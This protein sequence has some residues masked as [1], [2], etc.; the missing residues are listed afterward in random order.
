LRR[1]VAALQVL[2][3]S[4]APPGSKE[5]AQFLHAKGRII[6][7]SESAEAVRDEIEAETTRSL[8]AGNK[9]VSPE[10][11]MLTISSPRVPNLT[12]VDM[13]GLTKIATDGQPASIVR[14]L[15]EMSRAYI[16]PKNV[17]ILAISP[18]N[19]DIATSD[20]MRL[21]REFDPAGE[22]TLGVLTKLDLMDQGTDAREVLEG[23]A[24]HLKHGWIGVVNRSQ[25]DLN[26]RLSTAQSRAKETAFFNSKPV[27][28][29]LRT[30]TEE[31]VT[32]LGQQ[33]N[34]AIVAAIPKIQVFIN[35][36][37]SPLEKELAAL[38]VAVPAER[39]A[40][41]H[42]VMSMLNEF[43]KSYEALLASGRGG[44]ERVRV[45]LEN[46]LPSTLA[47][48]PFST[49]LTLR[50]VKETIEFA[51]GVQPY[52][53]APEHGIRRIICDALELLRTPSVSIVGQAHT[54]LLECIETTVADV[55]RNNPEMQR[56]SMLTTAI[57][58]CAAMSLES[59]RDE[60]S[61]TVA[62]L[63][64]M[65]SSYLTVSYFRE[66]QAAAASQ[67]A[68]AAPDPPGA[69]APPPKPPPKSALPKPPTDSSFTPE[70]EAQLQRVSTTV[71]AYLNSV[72][73]SLKKSIPKTVVHYQARS[74]R[75]LKSF[76]TNRLSFRRCSRRRS[77][78]SRRFMRR[79]ATVRTASSV[80]CWTRTQ[81]PRK[82][83][84]FLCRAWRC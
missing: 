16:R 20:A 58:R 13:P 6:D 31:L 23:K 60:A 22:R 37:I 34:S 43:Q 41:M 46:V 63:V 76:F 52:L 48:V 53:I 49:L 59:Y 57:K 56:Y 54:V 19:A 51:D 71:S 64:D 2:Q 45:V 62:V 35:D 75:F 79:C 1:L 21:V 32:S 8:G 69:P 4:Q 72:C 78:S 65:E 68:T 74:E 82:G 66:A 33:L 39:G 70:M 61:S 10:P 44:G 26:S 7:I 50:A 17:I 55:L 9:A 30:G 38:G 5:T 77:R 73:D 3:L 12:L 67:L 83:G 28:N 29:G 25:A 40:Q 84:S 27:Y 18:A 24:L 42:A 15:E 11:I 80:A 14:E 81:R 36:N 47:E